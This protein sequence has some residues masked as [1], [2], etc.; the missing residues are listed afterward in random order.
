MQMERFIYIFVFLAILACTGHGAK[1]EVESERNISG[2]TLPD[3]PQ[4][5]KG[6]EER[7]EYVAEHFWDNLTIADTAL[8]KSRRGHI[9]RFFVEYID[10]LGTIDRQKSSSY[11]KRFL[12]GSETGKFWARYFLRLADDILY[13]I[14]SPMTNEA[15]Y[16][17]FAES[18][19]ELSK[20]SADEL[21]K[22]M[23]RIE[24]ARKNNPG[25]KAA[26]FAFRHADG[27][28][29]SLYATNAG[30]IMVMFYDPECE[31][32][33]AILQRLSTS[34]IVKEMA[35]NKELTPI[36]VYTEGDKEVW[37]NYKDKAPKGWLNCFDSDESIKRKRLYELRAM[38]SIYLLDSAKR[39]IL[40]D[41]MPE[42]LLEFLHAL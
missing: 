33:S 17:P 23:Y 38:P 10:C 19:V 20:I 11:I 15:L 14:E 5:I 26:D 1:E 24:V 13:D 21:P 27:R 32:C 3:I 9:E 37:E 40:K 18:A 30:Y 22:Y 42:R 7:S 31:N 29:G 2:F 25:D 34:P 39:V 4:E 28:S 12:C 41:V 16:L 8:L 36:L 6:M 35:G